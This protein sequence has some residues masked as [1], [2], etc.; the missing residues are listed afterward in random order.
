MQHHKSFLDDAVTMVMSEE[1]VSEPASPPHL[2]QKIRKHIRFRPSPEQLILDAGGRT[3]GNDIIHLP[4]C[5]VQIPPC[6]QIFLWAWQFLLP[7][8][9]VV[10]PKWCSSG[11]QR[12]EFQEKQGIVRFQD[13]TLDVV[14]AGPSHGENLFPI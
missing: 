8:G 7:P 6:F 2:L 9:S 1:V 5:P 4:T 14:A 3:M 13:A 11:F 12:V 10:D